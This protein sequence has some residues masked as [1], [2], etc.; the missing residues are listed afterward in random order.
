MT[1]KKFLLRLER[2]I[3]EPSKNPIRSILMNR[4]TGCYNLLDRNQ[5][6]LV[7]NAITNKNY[8]DKN[9]INTEYPFKVFIKLEEIYGNTEIIDIQSGRNDILSAPISVYLEIASKCNLD[10]IGCYQGTRNL[11]VRTLSKSQ[12]KDF[13]SSF[14]QI[15]GLVI[16][17]TG[18]EPTTHP[19]IVEIVAHGKAM[20]LKM[21]LNTNGIM[22]K[23]KVCE[24]IDAGV[25]EVVVSIDGRPK[26]HNYLRGANIFDTALQ[27][28]KLF[29]ELNIDTRLNMTV[30][31]INKKDISFVANLANNLGAY[32]SYI[33]FRNIGKAARDK[34]LTAKEMKE[35]SVEVAELRK[36]VN[37]RLLTY[38]DIFGEE[39]DYYHPMFQLIPCH[40][41]KNIFVNNIGN[42][43]PCDH[44][45]ALGGVFCGGNIT[46]QNLLE[47]WQKGA[48]LE[49]YR[50]LKL[51][52]DC[53]TKCQYFRTNCYGGCISEALHQNSSINIIIP[54]D[55]LCPNCEIS[56]KEN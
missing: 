14:A 39:S 13:I 10:C 9:I 24:L 33:P 7:V 46:K 40:A 22:S 53:M 48:G 47:I 35:I 21:A 23:R 50:Q 18:K 6:T 30:S 56:D 32:V 36:E 51:S 16:R 49:K 52:N 28:V 25:S 2:F 38:F 44:L 37:V 45:V 12:I 1:S 41:R 5:T 31:P 11:A 20:G 43:Y 3:S 34:F 54:R 15:G 8:S 42:V 27:S 29:L 17:L 4:I 19:D 26:T 55:R